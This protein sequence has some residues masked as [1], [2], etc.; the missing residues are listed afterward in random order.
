MAHFSHLLSFSIPSELVAAQQRS[1]VTYTLARTGSSGSDEADSSITIFERRNLIS[2]SLT[3][4]FRTWEAALHLTTYLWSDQGRTMIEGRNIIELGAGTGL[5]S[6]LC[7]KYLGAAHVLATDGDQA[8]VDAL[9]ENAIVNEL[10][11]QQSFRACTLRWGHG[12]ENVS[13]GGS[14]ES[15]AYDVILGTDIVRDGSCHGKHAFD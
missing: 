13:S 5:L 4:G 9:A 11:M 10:E 7:A 1:Y 2:G 14:P 8:V 15:M 3:T 12:L 6:L